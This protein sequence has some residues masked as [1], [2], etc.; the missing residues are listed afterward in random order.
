MKKSDKDLLGIAAKKPNKG[1]SFMVDNSFKPS[2]ES[3]LCES[4][5]DC[6]VPSSGDAFVLQAGR[7]ASRLVNDAVSASETPEEDGEVDFARVG[8]APRGGR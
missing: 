6:V 5:C 8:D 3:S 2:G 7:S 4:L 1:A